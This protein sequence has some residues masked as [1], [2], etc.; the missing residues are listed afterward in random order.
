[1]VNGC[2]LS[3][4]SYWK[5]GCQFSTREMPILILFHSNISQC[6]LHIL[7]QDYTLWTATENFVCVTDPMSVAVC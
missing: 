4:S 2:A 6:S 7:G 3:A 5:T 1:M